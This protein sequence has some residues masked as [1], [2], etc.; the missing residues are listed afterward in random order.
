MNYH[1]F[2]DPIYK[3]NENLHLVWSIDALKIQ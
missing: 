3:Q 1:L 2:N